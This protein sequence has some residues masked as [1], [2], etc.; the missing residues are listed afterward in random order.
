MENKFILSSLKV[1]NLF[2]IIV[3]FLVTFSCA[4]TMQSSS[5][6][7]KA[8]ALERLGNSLYLEGNARE[9]LAKLLEAEKLD[10]SNP[11]IQHEIAIVYQK[12]DQFD[13]SLKYFKKA[14]DLKPDFPKAYNN[15]GILYFQ[16]GDNNN[17]LK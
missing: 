17:A 12:I 2:A 3:L 16:M 7:E 8:E 10:P 4:G 1:I 14:I 11:D 9:G 13:L 6:K 5:R 15:M